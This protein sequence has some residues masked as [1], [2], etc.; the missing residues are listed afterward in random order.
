MRK[1]VRFSLRTFFVVVTIVAVL[2]GTL[3]HRAKTQRDA[4]G[5]KLN[6]GGMV[7]ILSPVLATD[8]N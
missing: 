5:G 7:L 1:Y 3:V 2:V 6:A 4:A 8:S